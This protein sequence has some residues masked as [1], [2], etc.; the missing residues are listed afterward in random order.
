LLQERY[1]A[2]AE[3]N[4]KM[5]ADPASIPKKGAQ[6]KTLQQYLSNMI[7]SGD[8]E[9]EQKA[10]ENYKVCGCGDKNPKFSAGGGIWFCEKCLK[11]RKETFD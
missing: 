6:T 4:L 8:G 10:R 7:F 1:D 3:R 9:K 2:E 11:N 5:R